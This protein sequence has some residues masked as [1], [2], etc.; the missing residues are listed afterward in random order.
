MKWFSGM[1]RFSGGFGFSVFSLFLLAGGGD[2]A[3]LF[4]RAKIFFAAKGFLG[5]DEVAQAHHI[6]GFAL[7]GESGGGAF[8]ALKITHAGH[9]CKNVNRAPIGVEIE[10]LQRRP[11]FPRDFEK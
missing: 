7:F 2:G 10:V 6:I 8:Q 1:R 4:E 11:A 5:F 9:I 3:E